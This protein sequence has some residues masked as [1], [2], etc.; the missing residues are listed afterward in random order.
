M[1][2]V[3]AGH[4]E[5]LIYSITRTFSIHLALCDIFTVSNNEE[6]T[7]G[8]VISVLPGLL[9]WQVYKRV[10]SSVPA[11]RNSRVKE[12]RTDTEFRRGSLGKSEK[13]EI[14]W[15]VQHRTYTGQ[16]DISP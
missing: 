7:T 12:G 13:D 5:G 1:L 14:A 4:E 10:S 9:R 16:Y 3:G 2:E 11:T 15:S 6:R 8:P